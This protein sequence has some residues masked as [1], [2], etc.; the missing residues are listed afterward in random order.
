MGG[1]QR[2][3]EGFHLQGGVEWDSYNCC[4]MRKPLWQCAKVSIYS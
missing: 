1:C 3:Q 2:V 4:D